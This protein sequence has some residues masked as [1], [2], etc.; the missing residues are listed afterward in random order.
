MKRAVILCLGFAGAVSGLE[1]STPE[2]QGISS[3]AILAFVDAA[4]NEVDALHSL[5][6]VRHGHVVAEGWWAP[7]DADVPHSLHSL[8]KSFTSTA[9]GL[10]I[11]EGLVGLDDPL[12]SYIPEEA[13]VEPSDNLKAMRIRD[14]LSMSTGPHG[15]ALSA[16]WDGKGTQTQRF[17]DPSSCSSRQAISGCDC[18]NGSLPPGRS[19]RCHVRAACERSSSQTM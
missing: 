19:T 5:M 9:I 17:L 7:C 4:E 18:R 6:L 11:S 8:S 2:E 3:T 16:M 1:R 15:E 14:L 10:A 12:I 13:P